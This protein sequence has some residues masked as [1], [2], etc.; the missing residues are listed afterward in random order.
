MYHYAGNNP[1]KYTDPDG[2]DDEYNFIKD[3]IEGFKLIF[4]F[5]P[6]VSANNFPINEAKEL[7][8]FINEKPEFLGVFFGTSLTTG[9]LAW[10]GFDLYSKN[11]GFSNFIDGCIDFYNGLVDFGLNFQTMEYRN[12][13][14]GL[15]ST[16]SCL[17]SINISNWTFY[18]FGAKSSYTGLIKITENLSFK[19]NMGLNFTV[20]CQNIQN[21][22]M[23]SYNMTFSLIFKSEQKCKINYDLI[24]PNI[25][26]N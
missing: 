7:E 23:N 11:E 6:K 19:F 5:V 2:R 18:D 17:P 4:N 25:G 10:T 22:K 12:T 3:S 1:I 26:E 9:M 24:M 20:D 21:S 16:V 14:C 8:N 15:T 13:Y